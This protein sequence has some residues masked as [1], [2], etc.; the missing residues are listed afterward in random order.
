M[1]IVLK[2]FT[3]NCKKSNQRNVNIIWT[4][5][6]ITGLLKPGHSGCFLGEMMLICK[7]IYW[8]RKGIHINQLVRYGSEAPC[9]ASGLSAGIC[10]LYTGTI[11]KKQ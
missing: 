1:L 10:L 9:F 5:I 2:F 3:R 11:R 7:E 8:G 6:A 4:A